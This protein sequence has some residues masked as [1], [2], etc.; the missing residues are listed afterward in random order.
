MKSRYSTKFFPFSPGIPWT[1]KNNK[2]VV[3]K[4]DIDVWR[5]VLADRLDTT[6]IAHGGLLESFFSLALIEAVNGFDH[7]RRIEWLGCTEYNS[8][9][10][11]QGLAFVSSSKLTADDAVRYPVPLFLDRG[12]GVYFNAL[13][14]YRI[15]KAFNGRYPKR[16][17]EPIL[18]QIFD[19]ALVQWQPN[20]IPKLR[21]LGTREY[22]QW[23]RR[24]KVHQRQRYV[25]VCPDP[26]PFSK[27]GKRA[28]S[29]SPR[30]VRELSAML[31]RFGLAVIVCTDRPGHFYN[32]LLRTAPID[33]LEIICNLLSHA[34]M[35][36]S[37]DIDFLM[38]GMML[39]K[40]TIVG[41][42]QRGPFDLTRN[43]EF[44]GVENVICTNSVTEG[45]SPLDVH[46]ICEGLL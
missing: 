42:H 13:N 19:N 25:L 27:A 44:L 12:K 46:A 15:E 39:S 6:V 10:R 29:W 16:R 38:V 11:F 17:K 9:V 45:L 36:L 35:I 34:W 4:I 7:K 43:A 40:A 37:H 26:T 18:Q 30:E 23:G 1:I 24:H 33:N 28:L 20:Y 31:S 3:P 8:L 41:L 21:R 32:T 22:A 14:N 5:K 2:Y